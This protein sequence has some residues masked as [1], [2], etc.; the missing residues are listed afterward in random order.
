M[1]LTLPLS[2][3][4]TVKFN[5]AVLNQN[6]T[7]K[8]EYFLTL[9]V[10]KP[11]L[12]WPLVLNARLG[13]MTLTLPPITCN[14]T[15]PDL[16]IVRPGL[17]TLAMQMFEIFLWNDETAGILSV[18]KVCLLLRYGIGCYIHVWWKD[19]IL[20]PPPQLIIL[21]GYI[22]L[23][24]HGNANGHEASYLCLLWYGIGCYIHVS[25]DSILIPFRSHYLQWW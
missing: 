3:E 17:N 13:V 7:C 8:I 14:R 25:K 16:H 23:K 12:G 24:Q 22:Y 6:I 11:Q 1:T 5:P 10:P 20:A 19:S 15:T 2:Q 9:T 4:V 18:G 21:D